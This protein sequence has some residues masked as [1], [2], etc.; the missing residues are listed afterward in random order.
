[1]NKK[2]YI[3]ISLIMS[4]VFV[5]L[6]IISPSISSDGVL[7]IKKPTIKVAVIW[8]RW[9]ILDKGTELNM[10][11][12]RLILNKAENK[13]NVNFKLYEFWDTRLN[14]DIQ[15][16]KLSKLGIDV[17]I[18]PGGIGTWNSPWKYRKEIK[19]FVRKG[20]GFYGICGD[21]TFGSLGVVNLP[22][23]Y[24][25]LMKKYLGDRDFTPMLGFVN[26]YT[27]ATSYES[28]F[29]RPLLFG[30]LNILQFGIRLFK[31]RARIFMKPSELNIHEP[32]NRKFVRVMLGNSCL[33]DGPRLNNLIMPKVHTLATFVTQDKPFDRSIKGN[34][35]MVASTFFRGRVVLSSPH[36]ELTFESSKAQ[37]IF[38]RNL[39]WCSKIL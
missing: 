1:L 16:G 28:I 11:L 38:I 21:S 32:Y 34:M 39:L 24:K 3:F 10:L 13:Y 18:G 19:D 12:Y 35:A 8:Q 15:T 4:F 26:V 29:K 2:F 23:G 37:D 33:V 31:S 6:S 36:P 17:I 30:V 25:H 27:D 7:E 5:F 14:G 20:G 22:R 9:D